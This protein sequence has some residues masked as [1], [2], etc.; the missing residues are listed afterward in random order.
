VRRLKIEDMF[1]RFDTLDV[2]QNH[3]LKIYETGSVPAMELV[4]TIA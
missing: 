3:D 4:P 1:S 2:E